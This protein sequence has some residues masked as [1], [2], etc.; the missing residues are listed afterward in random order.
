MGENVGLGRMMG[1][2]GSWI[3]EDVVLER[4]SGKGGCQMSDLG[5]CWVEEDV[6]WEG[7]LVGIKD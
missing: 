2:G 1:W 4:M 6:G 7:R 3:R 5:G